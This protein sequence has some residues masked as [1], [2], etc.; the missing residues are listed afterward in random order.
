MFQVKIAGERNDRWDIVLAVG[1]R[2]SPP[3]DPTISEVLPARSS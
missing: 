3:G 1:A 2:G